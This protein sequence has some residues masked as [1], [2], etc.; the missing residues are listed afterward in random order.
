MSI[1]LSTQLESIAAE[2]NSLQAKGARKLIAVSG[3]PASGKSTIAA[4]LANRL[5]P[6]GVVVPMDGFH[7]DN[8]I[9]EF[10]NLRHVKGSPETFDVTGFVHL[11]S[12]L[13]T[14]EDVYF[15][16]FD[17]DLDISVAGAGLVTAQNEVVVIEGNYLFLEE[18]LWDQ[19][20]AFFDVKIL[21]DVPRADLIE[22]LHR[23][24]ERYGLT[25]EKMQSQIYENDVP[26]IDRVLAK[27]SDPDLMLSF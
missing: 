2:I 13:S 10:R 25:P 8:E 27:M 3:P 6:G 19:L 12:R 5:H 9:L 26:N 18:P 22:R 20:A 11:I 23:R 15:P 4:E 24:W 17:R 7:L 14:E 1:T 21:L 16:V